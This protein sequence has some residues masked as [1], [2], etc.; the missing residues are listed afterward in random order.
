MKVNRYFSGRYFARIIQTSHSLP[1]PA[2]QSHQMIVPSDTADHRM[3]SSAKPSQVLHLQISGFTIVSS[4]MPT[5]CHRS[6]SSL[7]TS[8]SHHRLEQSNLQKQLWFNMVLCSPRVLVMIW[9]AGSA[10][11]SMIA[12]ILAYQCMSHQTTIQS[13]IECHHHVVLAPDHH[14]SFR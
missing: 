9:G 13:T 10:F 7:P 3:H 1:A 5:R 2:H 12:A 8:L 14:S 6:L 4:Q 11:M